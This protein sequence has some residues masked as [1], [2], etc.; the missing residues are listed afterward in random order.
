MDDRLVAWARA[1]K[2]RHTRGV[3]GSL[4]VLWLFTD[5][6]RL[7]DPLGA[8]SRLPRGLAGVVLRDDAMPGRR[9][10]ARNLA[11][12][13]RARRLALAVAGDW[14]LAAAV[15]AGLH[16]RAGRRLAGAPRWLPILSSS[17]HGVAELR[18]ARCAGASAMFLSPVFDT[19]SHPGARTLGPVR[20]ARHC[21]GVR[22]AMALG[23]IDGRTARCLPRWCAG[24]GAIG[25]LA[26]SVT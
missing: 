21:R 26:S 3:A 14:R 25:S 22:G 4:P 5:A 2:A 20:W 17:A 8:A 9:T 24:V 13:C 11:R 10:L 12:I 6:A 23:G 7:A 15:G 18:R 1:V 19:G 16:L